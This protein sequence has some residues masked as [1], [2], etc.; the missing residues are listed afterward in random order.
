[1]ELPLSSPYFSPTHGIDKAAVVRA[2]QR[3]GQRVAFAGD[4]YPDLPAARLAVPELRFATSSL[5]LALEQEGLPFR[6]FDR[7][8]E[9]AQALL[10]E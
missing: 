6:R 1:M 7:W 5:A 2:A 8:S 3:S 9:V 4:G 10:G